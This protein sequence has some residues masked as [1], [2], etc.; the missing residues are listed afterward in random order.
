[1]KTA[2]RISSS[3]LL[4]AAAAAVYGLVRTGGATASQ[5]AAKRE[6]RAQNALV[7]LSPLKTA[8]QLAPLADTPEEQALA[9]DALRLADHAIDVAFDAALHDAETH[10]VTLSKEA[11]EIQARLRKAQQLLDAAD[12]QVRQLT[13]EE[14]KATGEKKSE[15]GD[16]LA[17]AQQDEELAKYEVDDANAD[18]IRA[19]GDPKGRIQK[20]KQEH[21]AATH[22]GEKAS[23]PTPISY[24]ERGLVNRFQQW[25]ALHGKRKMILQ[26]RAD[27]ESAAENLADRHDALD[28]RTEKEK[29]SSEDLEAHA[30]GADADQRLG[31]RKKRSRAETSALLEKT[32]KIADAQKALIT[33]DS[34]IDDQK[35]LADLYGQWDAIVAGRQRA[36]VRRILLGTLIIIVVAL[37]ALFF[38]TWMEQAL[39]RVRVDHRQRQTLRTITRVSLQVTAVLFILLVIFG[40][41]N[42]LGTVLGLAGAGLT[43]ALKDFIVGFMGW[44]VLMGKNGVRLGDWVEINGVMGE[45]VELGMFHTV[46]LETGNWTDSGHPTGRRVT[47][48]NSYAIEGHYFNFSTV[49]QWLWDELQLTLPSGEDP[50]PVIDAIQKTVLEAT[51]TSAQQAEKEWQA[52]AHSREMRTLSAAPA[53]NLKPVMGGIQISVRY[54]TRANERFQLRAKLY[55]SAVALLGHKNVTSTVLTDASP[56]PRS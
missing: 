21:E 28:E 44:F 46:L 25:F 22:E 35:E 33:I 13:A 55:Q 6:A 10:P 41:P 5:T 45:V 49:G 17:I 4:L 52:A 47:F 12:A 36:V 39:G 2:Q 23:A 31:V 15:L 30:E 18:L 16:Q 34:R 38:N 43:V 56:L 19:G 51:A 1:M 48:T 29:A 24:N 9:K 32:K 8:Q 54:V 27:A 7:D 50:Y 37:I 40:P 26:A 20:M 53:I 42:Q 14:G 11:Q 3:L